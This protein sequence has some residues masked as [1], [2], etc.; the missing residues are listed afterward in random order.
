MVCSRKGEFLIENSLSKPPLVSILV[1]TYNHEKYIEQCLDSLLNQECDFSYEI[2]IG[3]DESQDSTREICQ[4]YAR[5]YPHKIRLFLRSRDDVIFVN[6][7]PT[8]RYN[9]LETIKQCQGDYIAFCEGD[10]Y[11]TDVLK[12]QKQIHALKNNPNCTLCY[13]NGV[14]VSEKHSRPRAFYSDRYAEKL[15]SAPM[16]SGWLAQGNIVQTPTILA[17]NIFNQDA[18]PMHLFLG[19]PVGDWPFLQLLLERGDGVFINE[20]MA[21]YRKHEGGVW[22]SKKNIYRLQKSIKTAVVMI[23]SGCF[24]PQT[25]LVLRKTVSRWTRHV[26]NESIS[27]QEFDL[28]VHVLKLIGQESPDLMLQVQKGIWD[29]DLR[30]RKPIWVWQKT[31]RFMRKFLKST[32]L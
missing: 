23:G 26:W 18:I 30:H 5:K 6:D 12:L 29:L 2:C 27:L 31:M 17:V 11:W 1:T 21:A 16:T 20:R 14:E 24:S 28:V 15:C 22:S 19:T 13:T 8:G 32:H 10:D 7:S 3:E 25:C 4:A 9:F